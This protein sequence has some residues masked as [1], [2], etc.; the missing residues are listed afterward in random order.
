MTLTVDVGV[1]DV[2]EC[3]IAV[4]NDR[5][6][7]ALIFLFEQ[8]LH[9]TLD[10]VHFNIATIIA[11]NEHLYCFKISFKRLIYLLLI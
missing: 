11:R 6:Q 4:L 10:H 9:E 1:F 2:D 3:N 8:E 5:C 7:V